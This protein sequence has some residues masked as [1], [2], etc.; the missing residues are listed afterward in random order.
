MTLELINGTSANT[1]NV[2]VNPLEM[3]PISAEG[4]NITMHIC[5]CFRN[6]CSVCLLL[7]AALNNNTYYSITYI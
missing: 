3:S 1:F 6:F 7:I 5:D 2:S 4:K